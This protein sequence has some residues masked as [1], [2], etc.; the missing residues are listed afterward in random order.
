MVP[1]LDHL[2]PELTPVSGAPRVLLH[3]RSRGRG[4]RSRSPLPASPAPAP[5]VAPPRPAAIALLAAAGLATTGFV[6]S[7]C[8]EAGSRGAREI[9]AAAAA[10]TGDAGGNAGAAAGAL[11]GTFDSAEAAA[12]QALALIEAGDR[13]RI[14]KIALS[15]AEFRSLV[16]PALP[17][18]RPERNTSA[19]FLW[20]MLAQ[21]SRNSLAFTLDRYRGRPL[22]LVA[23]DF[24]GESTDYGPFRVHREAVLTVRHAEG[25]PSAVRLFGSM[26]EREGR[27]KIFSFVTD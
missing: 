7:G 22:E 21:R 17:A 15:E 18:S 4:S 3:P 6:G 11:A 2:R 19:E 25:E 12:R 23:V 9:P 13:D 1:R 26:I 10:A 27:F 14:G 5:G 20:G 8:G 16:Y 24:V